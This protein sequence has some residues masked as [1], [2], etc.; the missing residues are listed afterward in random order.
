MNISESRRVNMAEQ[1]GKTCL[2]VKVS[3]A[4]HQMLQNIHTAM[5]TQ[6]LF[7]SIAHD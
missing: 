3:T 2:P 6:H 4:K 1:K 5:Q 7:I